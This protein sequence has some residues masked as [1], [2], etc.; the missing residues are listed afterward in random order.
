MTINI[1][2]FPS[3]AFVFATSLHTSMEISDSPII[4]MVITTAATATVIH[5]VIAGTMKYVSCDLSSL[6]V[7]LEEARAAGKKGLYVFNNMQTLLNNLCQ[8]SNSYKTDFCAYY[9]CL[10]LEG[11]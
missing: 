4:A 1:V 6:S 5:I 3:S 8:G 10:A 11:L 7:A 2:K 9:V